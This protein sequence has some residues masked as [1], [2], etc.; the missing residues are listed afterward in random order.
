MLLKVDLEEGGADEGRAGRDTG[1]LDLFCCREVAFI[2]LENCNIVSGQYCIN[3]SLLLKS[4]GSL[5]ATG[6]DTRL[7]LC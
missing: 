2:I 3:V 7:R 5:V 1:K 6:L 4:V